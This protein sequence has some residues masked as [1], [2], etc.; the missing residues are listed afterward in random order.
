MSII[1][2]DKRA[3]EALAEMV[4]VKY[5]EKVNVLRN[6]RCL[7]IVPLGIDKAEGLRRLYSMLA[8]SEQEVITIGDELNDVAM[9]KTYTS[10]AMRQGNPLLIKFVN[11]LVDSVAEIIWKELKLYYN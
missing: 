3:V 5:G 9:L 6:G 2:D 7:D 11:G 8:V 1:L 4:E 10:Y